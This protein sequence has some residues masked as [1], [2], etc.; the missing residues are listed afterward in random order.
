MARKSSF[1]LPVHA[2]DEDV[3][4]GMVACSTRAMEPG[5]DAKRVEKLRFELTTLVR[6]DPAGYSKSGNPP[7][8]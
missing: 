1:E 3:G 4:T 7:R 8:E 5:E 2:L 6:G